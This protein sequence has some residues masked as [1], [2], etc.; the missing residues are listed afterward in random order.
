MENI[1][2]WQEV[3]EFWIQLNKVVIPFEQFFRS[4]EKNI[5]GTQ[6]L[7]IVSSEIET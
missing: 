2:Y 5:N 7:D 4:D 1:S 3:H 6:I